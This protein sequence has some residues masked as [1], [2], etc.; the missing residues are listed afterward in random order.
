MLGERIGGIAALGTACLWALTYLQ[1]TVAVR[2]IGPSRL[3]RLRLTVALLALVIAHSIVYR[4]PIPLDADL[5]RWGWLLLS[6]VIGFAISDALLFRALLHVGAHRTSLVMALI[7][8]VSALLAWRLFGERLT[9]VQVA[10][11]GITVVGIV[12][13]I[14][15]RRRSE[16]HRE[17]A[18]A[19]GILFAL[20][21][22]VAQSMRYIL[23]VQGMRGGYPVLS[24]N[25][26]QILAATGAIWIAALVGR[27]W[28]GTFAAPFDRRA[29]FATVGGSVT[30]P[31]LGVTLSLVALAR[32]P[33][34]VA[35]TLMA[36]VPVL[37]LP[38]AR[39]GF[40]EA[41]G[42]RAVVGTLLAVGGVAMLL[43]L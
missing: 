43:L 40:R 3:N 34:G 11:A 23:S 29:A 5:L 19:A 10:G 35:S 21:A 8:I 36:I 12:A 13:V 27:T 18:F 28:R 31:F 6:G 39:W 4:T 26:M 1:F 7:P 32:A 14:S 25:L 42:P 24:T 37:L 41:I 38:V 22:V 17:G 33:V 20:G 9:P 2:V 15:D 16:L 30:G